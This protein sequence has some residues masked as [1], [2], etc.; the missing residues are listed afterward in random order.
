MSSTK[1]DRLIAVVALCALVAAC[2]SRQTEA[3]VADPLSTDHYA[4]KAEVRAEGLL[5]TPH[6]DGLSPAQRAAVNDMV[7]RWRT[8]PGGPIV[9]ETPASGG[10]ATFQAT[11]RI[12]AY[13]NG[14]GVREPQVAFRRYQ[15]EAAAPIRVSFPIY[16]ADI[17]KCGQSWDD[18]S[19]PGNHVSANFGCAVSANIASMIANPGDLINARE[20][21]P[22][23]AGRRT[24][25]LEKYREG[26]VTSSAWDARASSKAV[27]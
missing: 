17:P 26:A 23:D 11:S 25:V 20:P 27:N 6:P 24:A 5:L 12:D 9:V 18:L 3:S 16:V 21:T 14:L 8:A 22:I 7:G 1:P 13:L 10:E 19:V 4:P 15:G 2:A